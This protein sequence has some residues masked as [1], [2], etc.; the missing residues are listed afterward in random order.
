MN[1]YEEHE[2]EEDVQDSDPEE[3]TTPQ[4]DVDDILGDIL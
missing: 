3:E 2:R 4:E 1:T